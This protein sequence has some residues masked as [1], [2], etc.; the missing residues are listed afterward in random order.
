[1]KKFEGMILFEGERIASTW[2]WIIL[3]I[4]VSSVICFSISTEETYVIIAISSIIL[5]SIIVAFVTYSKYYTKSQKK[6]AFEINHEKRT[7]AIY[8]NDKHIRTIRHFKYKAELRIVRGLNRVLFYFSVYD[9]TDQEYY[10]FQLFDINQKINDLKFNPV[11]ILSMMIPLT[12]E[13][14]P[15]FIWDTYM[16]LKNYSTNKNKQ[17][18]VDEEDKF[19]PFASTTIKSYTHEE[20]KNRARWNET[21][22]INSKSDFYNLEAFKSNKDSLAL[23]KI[24]KSAF[25]DITGKSLLHLQCHFGMSTLSFARMGADVTGVDFSDKAINLAQSLSEELSIPANFVRSNIYDLREN[26]SEKFDCVFTSY[27]VLTWL[28]DIPEWAR[29]VTHFLKP[30]GTFFISEFHPFAGIF[31]D[32]T[33]KFQIKYPYFPDGKPMRFDDEFSY[34]D[35][36]KLK[37]TE[38]YEWTH[39]LEEILDS[40]LKAGL[41]IQ[42]YKEYSHARYQ[43]FPF[44]KRI[45]RG[46]YRVENDPIPLMFSVKATKI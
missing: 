11:A 7:F 37:N 16:E 25:G 9:R 23:D 6:V 40:I 26:L 32:E 43:M 27:G 3:F 36:T 45:K 44:M 19:S 17:K 34:A 5:I 24:E 2:S 12:V 31:D 8:I 35:D 1:M 21:A 18:P 22:E 20:E 15:S 41:Q 4:I 13:T 28:K 33:E 42:E 46:E 38:A 30:G 14:H 10:Y 39:S 29:I